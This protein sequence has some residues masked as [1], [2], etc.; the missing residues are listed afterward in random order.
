MSDLDQ[1]RNLLESY[2]GS[3]RLVADKQI[4]PTDKLEK[5]S[6]ENEKI[7]LENSELEENLADLRSFRGMRETYAKKIFNFLY[8]YSLFCGA[9]FIAS[10]F[11][12]WSFKLHE[13]ALASLAGSTAISVVGAAHQVVSGLF[14]S[15]KTPSSNKTDAPDS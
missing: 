15:P 4:D 9:I 12:V 6:L 2:L 11:S 7:R 8:A 1:T 10:G 14:G 13:I 3:T 5:S